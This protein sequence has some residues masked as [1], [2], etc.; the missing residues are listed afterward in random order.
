MRS[1]ALEGTCGVLSSKDFDFVRRWRH[2]RCSFVNRSLK[3]NKLRREFALSCPLRNTGRLF[4]K[5]LQLYPKLASYLLSLCQ[6]G[7]KTKLRREFALSFILKDSNFVQMLVSICYP[8]FKK[9]SGP[10]KEAKNQS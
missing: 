2:F 10:L 8:F 4:A 3:E 7:S 5:R 1:F 6:R 9:S